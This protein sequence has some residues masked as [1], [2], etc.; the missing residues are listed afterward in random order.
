MEEGRLIY[1]DTLVGQE[2][3]LDA[4]A[5]NGN[6]PS[7]NTTIKNNEKKQGKGFLCFSCWGKDRPPSSLI[8]DDI[9]S[10]HVGNNEKDSL[11]RSLN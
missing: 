10:V 2:E 7:S 3:L 4:M 6:Y 1:D 5:T 8:P 9:S 11:E